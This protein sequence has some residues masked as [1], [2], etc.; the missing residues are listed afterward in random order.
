MNSKLKGSKKKYKVSLYLNKLKNIYVVSFRNPLSGLR[1]SKS[2][3]ELCGLDAEKAEDVKK[4][5]ECLINEDVAELGLQ[6]LRVKYGS[7]ILNLLGSSNNIDELGQVIYQKKFDEVRQDEVLNTLR[8]CVI[9]VNYTD[10]INIAYLKDLL[11]MSKALACAVESKI[12]LD[13]VL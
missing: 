6:S 8:E 12:L 11:K 5:L 7:A 3:T 10:N 13:E 9:G 2:L 4:E 1:M